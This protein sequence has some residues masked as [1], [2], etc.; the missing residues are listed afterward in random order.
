MGVGCVGIE[1]FVWI[2]VFC[3]GVLTTEVATEVLVTGVLT[4]GLLVTGVLDVLTVV[5]D[6]SGVI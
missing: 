6:C 2:D 4:I 3:I 1:V 5:L